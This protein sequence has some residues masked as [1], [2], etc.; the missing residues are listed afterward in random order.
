[1][2]YNAA[3]TQIIFRAKSGVALTAFDL[4]AIGVR[5]TRKTAL[6]GSVSNM[7]LGI[8]PDPTLGYDS[9]NLNNNFSRILNAQ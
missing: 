1:V 5:V 6:N 7:T 3:K 4:K 9:D 8:F 2:F